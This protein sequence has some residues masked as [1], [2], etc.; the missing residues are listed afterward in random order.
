MKA[1]VVMFDTLNRLMLPPYGCDWARAPHFTRLAERTATF[2]RC[3][4]GSMP[5][6]PARREL[7][8][9]R[10]NFL[11]RSW[12]PLE[13]FDD[14][15][16][17]MLRD[18][19]IHTHLVTDHAHYWE[20]G[21]A[22][23]HGRYSTFEFFRGQ[24]GDAW[25]GQV[26]EP[27]VPEGPH[28]LTP[29]LK[30]DL[31]RQ[32]WVNRAHLPTI[33][34]HPQT[35]TFDAGIEFIT[36]NAAEDGWFCQIETFDPH[37]PFLSYRDH[38]ERYPHPWDGGHFDWPSYSRV[39]EAPALVE[40]A[41]LQYASLL[42]MCDDSLGRVLDTMDRLQLWD[43]TLLI[44]C[45]D[46]G[47]LLGEHGW[48]GKNVQPWY[49]ETIHTPLFVWDPRTP[50]MAGERV[51]AV[52]Q[53]IDIG[54]T[55]LEHFTVPATEHMQGRALQPVLADG[56]QIRDAALFGSFGGHVC[57]CDGRY[58]YM[59]APVEESNAPLHEHTLM[60]TRMRGRMT[61][62]E[63]SRATLDR[64]FSFTKGAPVLKMAAV[65]PVNP[66]TFGTLMFD[67]AEDPD[68]LRPL[69]DDE[70]EL[71]LATRLR[72]LMVASEAPAEQ[73]TRLGLPPNG[74]LEQD[75]LL[76]RAQHASAVAAMEG[77]VPV[78]DLPTGPL[79]MHTPLSVLCDDA[80]AAAVLQRHLPG[81]LGPDYRQRLAT[82][83]P[84]QIDAL[85]TS[86]IPG[87]VLRAAA[88]ELAALPG[89]PPTLKSARS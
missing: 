85:P 41:V 7:H 76:A 24:E 3:Y 28:G 51:D 23:Y 72:D 4:A 13:P 16:P 64:S 31:W 5:C 50:Q 42:S 75:H 58:V 44:V 60:P 32:D 37:E 11:H 71:R 86:V 36:T 61:P 67:L 69:V 15:V 81:L 88:T 48:W 79:S 40:H 35:L 12:G 38:Q 46:H 55:L 83:S 57:C 27:D 34:D 59:R 17:E 66:Y 63:L 29:L 26:A 77:A 84:V 18:A 89:I 14:S 56:E 30:S 19:G 49:E 2:D 33:D 6:M 20:D 8:T 54:P 73:F 25:K 68:Q 39:N 74:D 52:V 65:S 21:G 78:T 10:H 1:I 87:P 53:T 70:L 22:T 43:E 62:D 82:L 9:A 80:A 45:T 47:L